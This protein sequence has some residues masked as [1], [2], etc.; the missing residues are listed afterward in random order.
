MGRAR[1]SR[2]R[3]AGAARRNMHA[4]SRAGRF[5]DRHPAARRRGHARMR[6]RTARAH[7]TTPPAPSLAVGHDL[8][9][10][11]ARDR[12]RLRPSHQSV[13]RLARSSPSARLALD[14]GRVRAPP[15][16]LI[17]LDSLR[18]TREMYD[19]DVVL[20][21]RPRR[22]R[23]RPRDDAHRQRFRMQR[24]RARKIHGLLGDGRNN[25]PRDRP[26]A[27][28]HRRRS[29]M[30]PQRLSPRCCPTPTCL[31]ADGRVIEDATTASCASRATG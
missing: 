26:G 30:L 23:H 7:Q 5:R 21:R 15:C 31:V 19:V 24:P 16:A 9:R 22:A 20:T 6:D 2:V 14:D 12:P 27:V 28:G 1:P 3:F 8:P 29:T 17:S 25:P 10:R 11:A 4:L 18:A 13:P